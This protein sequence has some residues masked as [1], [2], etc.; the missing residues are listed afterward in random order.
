MYAITNLSQTG[1]LAKTDKKKKKHLTYRDDSG[2][3]DFIFQKCLAA[4]HDI[5]EGVAAGKIPAMNWRKKKSQTTLFD[6]NVKR[7]R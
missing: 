6:T 4:T 5:A 1:Y 7:Q 2:F 3:F